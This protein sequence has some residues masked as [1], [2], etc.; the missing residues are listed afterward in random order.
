M[1]KLSIIG[2]LLLILTG[3]SKAP[4][5]PS[6]NP[7][8]YQTAQTRPVSNDPV[9]NK[10]HTQYKK[11]HHTPYK[12]GGVCLDGVDC[13]GLVELIYK[14]AFGIIIPRSTKKQIYIGKKIDYAQ[15]RPG[16]LVF[17]KTGY[18]KRHVGIYFGDNTFLHS[19]KKYGVIISSINNPYWRER[20][21]MSRRVLGTTRA[22]TAK[23]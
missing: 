8:T 16:D 11:W 12:Y 23:Y 1:I 3:C 22:Y 19:S 4:T 15:I 6:H 20:Y 18:N 13:S 5:Y 2:I 21:W 17:F 9:I 14:D 7:Q 10:L